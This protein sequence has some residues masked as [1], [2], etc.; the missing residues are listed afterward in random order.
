M[1]ETKTL[2]KYEYKLNKSLDKQKEHEKSMLINE[3]QKQKKNLNIGI[4]GL[5]DDKKE[6]IADK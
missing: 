2:G 3:I 6:E 5:V 4:V 1:S